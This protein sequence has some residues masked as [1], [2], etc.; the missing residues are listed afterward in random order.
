MATL[1]TTRDKIQVALDEADLALGNP[2]TSQVITQLQADKS[3]LQSQ[4]ST[5]TNTNATLQSKIDKVKADL[6]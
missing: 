3:A 5:L 2:T 6:A 1:Q 4:V